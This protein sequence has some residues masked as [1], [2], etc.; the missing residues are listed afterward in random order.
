LADQTECRY[1][2]RPS[3]PEERERY[4]TWRRWEKAGLTEEQI[5]AKLL[6]EVERLKRKIVSLE[7]P[8]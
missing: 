3:T 1:C 2:L 7:N 5:S 6:K 8:A 4:K